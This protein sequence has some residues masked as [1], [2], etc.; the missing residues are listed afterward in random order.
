M[1]NAQFYFDRPQNEPVKEYRRGTPERLALEE[2]LRRQS[3]TEVEIPLIIGGKEIRTGKTGKV[4]M[5][6]DHQ[7]VLATYHMATEKE[8]RMAIAAA[9]EA[10]R[11]WAEMSWVER[12]SITLKVATLVSSK[13][14]ALMNAATMLGQSKNAYQAEIEAV[15]ELTDFIRFN[16]HYVSEIYN[17]QPH[18]EIGNLNRVEYRPLEGFV[19]A[20]SPFNFTAIASNLSLAPVVL[21]NTVVWKPA[22][23]SLLSN[24]YLMQIFKEAGLPDGVINFVPGSGGLIGD[25]VLKNQDLGGIHFTGS[26]G[27]FDTIWKTVGENLGNYR[28]YPR[29]V[30]ETGGKDFVVVH[31]SAHVDEVATALVRGAFEY[32]GQKCSAASRAYIPESLWPAIREKLSYNIGLIKQGDVRDF[33]NFVNAVIDEKAFDRIMGYIEKARS[34]KDAEV[35]LGGGGDKSK[36]YFIEPTVIL[37]KDPHFVTMEEEIFGPVLSVYVYEDAAFEQTLELV[38]STSPYGLTGAIFA[39]DRQAVVKATHVL[40]YAAGN[41]Y[42]NDKPTGAV[43]GQQPFGGSRM[44]GTND[45]AGSYLNLL[46]WITPRTV[47]ETFVPPTDFRYPFMHEEKCYKPTSG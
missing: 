21:G 9:M 32:Q 30:G 33:C 7:H 35:I 31:A 27:T 12:T 40:R 11:E 42:V 6:H 29:V 46:R 28:S 10:H 38:N 4:V 47:K 16:A 22:T 25:V 24:Y 36:G 26:N 34:S 39:K 43:V 41:L 20:V 8:V 15:C 37:A 23:T 14:R 5:P 13:Y 45:K 2:E 17:D 19:F 18:S 1:N 44:S 3:G